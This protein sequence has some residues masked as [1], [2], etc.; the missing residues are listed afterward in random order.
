M[1]DTTGVGQQGAPANGKRILKSRW[2]RVVAAGTAVCVLGIAIFVLVDDPNRDTDAD[3]LPDRLEE[4]GWHTAEGSVFVTDP[5][6]ADTDGDGLLDGEEAGEVVSADGE[7]VV[8]AGSSDPLDTDT[9]GDGLDDG[10]ESRGWSTVSGAVYQTDP[11]RPDSDGDGLTDS[12]EAGLAV[13]SLDGE[14]R[15]LGVSDPRRV[16]SDEDGLADATET[17][18]WTSAR[19]ALY[20]TDPMSADSDG[21]GLTDLQE[22]GALTY[23]SVDGVQFLVFSNPLV[24]D[25]DDDGLTDLDEADLSLD[26]FA[27]DTDGDGLSDGAEVNEVGSSPGL[28]DTDGD[29]FNDGF[30]V[31]NRE[32]QGLDPLWPDVKITPMTYA[33][34]FAAGAILGEAAPSDSIAWLAGNLASSTSSFIPG[35]GWVVGGAADLRDAIALAI[36]TDWVGASFSLA[37]FVPLAGDV[38]AVPAKV[39]SFVTRHPELAAAVG[40][41][42]V[43]LKWVP[44]KTKV[45]ALRATAPTEW[46]SL[47]RVGFT[48]SALVKLSEGKAGIRT[49]AAAMSNASHVPGASAP[50]MKTGLDGENFLEN[51]L[52]SSAVDVRTQVTASTSS[53]VEVCNAVARRFDIVADGVA[54]ESKVGYVDLDAATRRQIESDAFAIANGDID[55][56]HWHFL[57]SAESK[58]IGP[59]APV[60]ELLEKYGIPFTIHAPG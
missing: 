30:E 31:A 48:E 35:V 59:S 33:T 3:G 4:D 50:F 29:G 23:D 43:A 39:A 11:S 51:L 14:T 28:E 26:P 1:R 24:V 25:S 58:T 34:E 38:T 54:H 10:V 60:V 53:C 44:D 47:L 16:D 41:M 21:D 57:A 32:T 40:A 20:L 36:H 8:Y 46:D 27:S 13:P 52:R 22:A 2:S 49:V 55:S 37:G 42:V 9:D 6:L 56:A 19:G 7:P 45:A 12:E 15:Y 18:G 5:R 17:R